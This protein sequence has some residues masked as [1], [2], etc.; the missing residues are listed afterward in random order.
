MAQTTAIK[1]DTA[2]TAIEVVIDQCGQV[3]SCETD[4]N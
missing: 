4:L 3:E 1:L 2:R